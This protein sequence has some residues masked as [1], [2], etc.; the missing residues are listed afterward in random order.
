MQA[1]LQLQT[2]TRWIGCVLWM[3]GQVCSAW[4]PCCTSIA[5]H[6]GCSFTAHTHTHTQQTIK[7]RW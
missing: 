3:T 1:E 2:L 4:H 6:A 7:S 5:Q